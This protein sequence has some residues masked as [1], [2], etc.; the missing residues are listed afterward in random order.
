MTIGHYDLMA[1][2][3]RYRAGGP[4]AKAT[5]LALV[6]R[7]GE[8]GN[9]WTC[10]PSQQTLAA[11]TEQTDRSVRNHLAAFADAGLIAVRQ[12]EIGERRRGNVYVLNVDRLLSPPET[13]SGH[14]EATT[15]T[16]PETGDTTTGTGVPPE[17]QGN[18]EEPPNPPQAGGAASHRGQ[19]TNCRACGTNRRGPAPP[20][21]EAAAQRA[22]AAAV[23]SPDARRGNPCKQCG[24]LKFVEALDGTWDQCPRCKGSGEEPSRR[25]S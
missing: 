6:E 3:R 12:R 11:D 8:H 19:H 7:M 15:G 1:A 14:G 10:W 2:A 24:D 5:L 23:A 16:P 25:V 20:D 17:E 22:R 9:E 4:G 21:P 13:V 18:Y